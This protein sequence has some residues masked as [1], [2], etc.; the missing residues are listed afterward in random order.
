MIR[1]CARRGQASRRAGTAQCGVLWP[2]GRHGSRRR[3]RRRSSSRGCS[4][5]RTSGR[6]A[7]RLPSTA[8]LIAEHRAYSWIGH[9]CVALQ[10]SEAKL[11][12]AK[13]APLFMPALIAVI[14]TAYCDYPYPLLRL[15]VPLTLLIHTP[16]RMI[17]TR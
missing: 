5:G 7:L 11:H 2:N 6:R 13:Q 15:F 9:A 1:H 12:S 17:R 3:R 8:R 4:N 16:Y 14:R 10:A